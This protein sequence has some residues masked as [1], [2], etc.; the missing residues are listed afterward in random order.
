[1]IWSVSV[2]LMINNFVTLFFSA[3]YPQ[4]DHSISLF[5][6]F[7][8]GLPAT[9]NCRVKPGKLSQYYSVSWWNGSSTIATSD[10]VLPRYE[11][12]DNFSLAIK[13]AQPSDSSTNY[14]CSVTINDPQR[15]GNPNIDYNHKQLPYINVIV[16]GKSPMIH[17]VSID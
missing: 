10:S 3:A 6:P 12:N 9:V 1:M 7:Q 8:A 2:E 5:Y 17:I 14:R 11:L 16:Y 15:S 4:P 13:D